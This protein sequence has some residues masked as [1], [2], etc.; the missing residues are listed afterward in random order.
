MGVSEVF[1]FFLLEEGEGR[2]RGARKGSYTGGGANTVLFGKNAFPF[3]LQG[4]SPP[5]AENMVF[6][7]HENWHFSFRMSP[8]NSKN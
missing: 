6:S 4:F 3:V 5:K 7:A 1:N 8:N 2:V